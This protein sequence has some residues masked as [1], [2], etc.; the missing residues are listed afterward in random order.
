MENVIQQPSQGLA[1]QRAFAASPLW[2]WVK[3]R[4]ESRP[5]LRNVSIMLTGTASGQLVS[6][7]LSPVL[8][9]LYSPEQFGLLSIYLAIISV[10]AVV[11]ALRYE[12]TLPLATTD[13]EMINLAA[14]C[15]CSLVI[16]TAIVALITFFL[17][18]GAL[19]ALSRTAFSA[20]DLQSYRVLLPIG[21]FCLGGYFIALY[22]AT[23]AGAF[24]LIAMS[25][26]NQGVVGPVTQIGAGIA[27]AG[28]PGLLIGSVLGQSAG[29]FGLL[30]RIIRARPGILRE[31]S[32]RQMMS[33]AK[34]YRHF[35]LIG[36]WTALIDAAGGNQLLY[37]LITTHYAASIAG[38]LFLVERVVARPLS[39]VGTS[40]LQVFVGEAGQTAT[41]APDKLKSRFRQVVHHQF[42]LAMAWILVA[43]LGAALFF[44]K[45][46]GAEWGGA[47]IYLQAMSLGYLAQAVVLPVFHTLQILERQAMAAWWQVFRLLFIIAIFVVGVHFDVSAVWI[48][49]GYSLAQAIAGAILL[50]LMMNAIQQLQRAPT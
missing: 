5:F 33:L 24:R 22:M 39:M 36:S 2:R 11:A 26:L 50:I 48:V 27:G 46:F 14:V 4:L 49:M 37:L 13:A 19:Q 44:P 34:R 6:I 8:T 10:L 31:V 17:P 35:P 47:V 32:W 15:G 41:T 42:F 43:N 28:A 3:E 16:T 38:F 29:T 21:F 30:H 7:L 20:V 1:I 12:L 40:I 25:R 9:R 23:R 18:L 45:V